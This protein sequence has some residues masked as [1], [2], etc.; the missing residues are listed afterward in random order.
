[1]TQQTAALAD[2]PTANQT[3]TQGDLPIVR[4]SGAIKT[5][6][7]TNAIDNVD[8]DIRP[9]ELFTLLGPSGS[10][11]STILRAIAGLISIDG[12]QLLIEGQD[13]SNIPTYR[14]NVGMVFQSLALFP[15]MSVFDNIAFPLKMRRIGRAEV[16]RRVADALDIV[17]LPRIA[18]RKVHELSGGQ[19]Q[20]VALARSLV[21][22]PS[23]LLLDEPFGALDKRLREEMQLEVV[24]LHKEIDVT[25]INVTH[26]Q[27]EAMI[28]SDRIGVMNEGRLVQVA[29]GEELYRR[30]KTRFVADFLGRS[31]CIDGVLRT[32]D[33]SGPQL[34]TP[35]GAALGVDPG[36][37]GTAGAACTAI[38]RAE[39]IELLTAKSDVPGIA[40]V[41][42]QVDLRLFEG[43]TV[44]YEIAV[45]GID[46]RIR[47]ASRSGAH[48][49]GASV[50]LAWP[51][52]RVWVVPEA[53]NGR[54]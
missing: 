26:D 15:H 23:L 48:A 20:R 22:N 50:W 5:Y 1:M 25:I 34:V 17:R 39:D 19:Q 45:A 11:K 3:A 46:Q 28:L 54:A 51:R 14:R 47:V 29:A 53:A 33:G 43:E 7:Q 16:V 41:A 24:R 18:E 13:V 44:Y 40:G 27:V 9:R 35:G 4:L 8:L 30:P 10:G 6:G 2:S 42:G 38:L 31:N 32:G 21:Y 12:G 49:P 36:F 37:A 52:E